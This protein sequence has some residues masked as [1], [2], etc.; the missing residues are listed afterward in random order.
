MRITVNN[1]TH[2]LIPLLFGAL[3]SAA[4]FASVFLANAGC[5]AIGGIVTQ[6]NHALAALGH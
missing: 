5:L 4:G 1:A 3:G 2:F 6:R